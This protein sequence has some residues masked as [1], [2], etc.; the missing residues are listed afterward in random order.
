MGLLFHK[1]PCSI[2]SLSNSNDSDVRAFTL[3]TLLLKHIIV[4]SKMTVISTP[5]TFKQSKEMSVTS[6][7]QKYPDVPITNQCPVTIVDSCRIPFS[8]LDYRGSIF[9]MVPHNTK[10]MVS[11]KNPFPRDKCSFHLEIDG[12]GMGAWVLKAGASG[13]FERPTKVNQCFTFMSTPMIANA[14][15]AADLV[16]SSPLAIYDPQVQQALLSAPLGTGIDAKNTSN[17]QV[18]CTFTPEIKN[19][20]RHRNTPVDLCSRELRKGL[21]TKEA[22]QEQERNFKKTNALFGKPNSSTLAA[23][24]SETP[25][26]RHKNQILQKKEESRSAAR[27]SLAGNECKRDIIHSR[28]TFSTRSSSSST[29]PAT[30]SKKKCTARQMSSSHSASTTFSPSPTLTPGAS[31]LQGHSSQVFGKTSLE[32]D[33]SR[34][35][36]FTVCMVASVPPPAVMA[37]SCMMP[38][39]HYPGVSMHAGAN[40]PPP[41]PLALAEARP[42]LHHHDRA[43][44]IS[45]I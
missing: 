7:S 36:T 1:L 40:S 42:P 2:P 28:S 41:V 35:L 17:G 15:A 18:K 29:A 45:L 27:P 9:Y 14:E 10:F 24:T 8:S 44:H 39:C 6:R 16:A 4:Y 43:T 33:P 12:V 31:T 34:A 21:A 5:A 32:K 26:T 13:C 37:P 22:C 11:V 30:S 19:K 20:E 38:P 3:F 25:A 23:A